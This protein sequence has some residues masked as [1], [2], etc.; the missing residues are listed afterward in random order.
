MVVLKDAGAASV[1]GSRASNGVIVVTT[2]RGSRGVKVTY[3]MFTGTQLPGAEP[4][5]DLLTADEYAQLQ[6]LIY[7]ADFPS[8]RKPAHACSYLAPAKI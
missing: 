6:W 2:K 1:Y 3:D 8:S 7:F 4:T 5:A